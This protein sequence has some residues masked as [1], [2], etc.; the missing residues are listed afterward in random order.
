MHACRSTAFLLAALA[1][2]V[3]ASAGPAILI[4]RVYTSPVDH[5]TRFYDI[6]TPTGYT[7]A[8]A[9][10]LPAVLFLHG[11]GGSRGAFEKASYEAEADARGYILIFWQGR[12]DESVPAYSTD[13][14][15]G[16]RG[17]PDETDVLACLDNAMANYRIDSERVHLVGFSQGGKGALLIGL[18]NPD[19]FAT[20][21]EGAGPSDAFQG[22]AWSPGFPDYAAAAGGDYRGGSGSVL[23]RWFAQSPRFYLPNGRNLPMA[24]YHGTADTTVPDSTTLFPYRNTHH[25]ADTPGFAD[26]RGARP[27]LSELHRDDPSGYSYQTSYPQGVGH[28]EEEVLQAKPL[29]DFMSGKRR[30]VRPE[31][32]VATSYDAAERSYYWA[33]LGRMSPLDGEPAGFSATAEAS[34]NSFTLQPHGSPAITLRVPQAGLDPL[35]PLTLQLEPGAASLSSLRLSGAFP[36]RLLVTRNSVVLRA[37]IDF[38]REGSD[39]LFSALDSSSPMR[40][41]LQEEPVA[42]VVE[43]DLLVPALV[44]ASGQLGARFST[45]LTVANLGNV[46]LTVDA[47][48]LDGSGAATRLELA[49][50]RSQSFPSSELFS[51]LGKSGGA[52]PLRL[53]VVSGTPAALLASARVFNTLTR[54]GTYGLSFPVV[55]AG[56]SVLQAGEQAYFFGG[57]AEHPARTNISL[58]APFEGVTARVDLVN[59][60]GTTLSSVPV[61]LLPLARVQLDD[62]LAAVPPPGRVLVTVESG[63]AQ[64]YGTVV[65]NSVTNDP[66]RSPALLRSANSTEWTV[67]AVAAAPGRNGA[68]FSSDI[69]LGSLPGVQDFFIDVEL[70]FRSR[71]GRPPVTVTTAIIPGTARALSDVIGTFFPGS[72]PGAGALEIRSAFGLELLAVTRS[73]SPEGPASQDLPCFSKDQAFTEASPAAFAGVSEFSGARSNLVLVNKG[74]ST[75]VTLRLVSE[76]GFSIPVSVPLLAGEIKQIDS[77]AR[78]LSTQ[79]T[80][81]SVLLVIPAP[82]GRLVASVARIDNLTNDPSG[83]APLSFPISFAGTPPQ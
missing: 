32:V 78:L 82:G 45:E 14:I 61:T 13:Y 7:A 47:L 48:L 26:S 6:R 29:F 60:F 50:Q 34:G 74:A 44:E 57:T 73:D 59:D 39:V 79:D 67:P 21:S 70:T 2:A 83:L 19:R 10:P 72:V 23:A 71:D 25:I 53:R 62:V 64:V 69:F 22:Q 24:L 63:R 77:V 3:R 11:R 36:Q 68:T 81:S 9:T 16:V 35:R 56:A 20:L 5:A 65:S 15:D 80:V 8:S 40:L 75:S 18:K 58:F 49:P 12:F 38:T 76:T 51:R 4:D 46:P 28:S 1:F 17:F 66:F 55:A 30:V 31:R 54:G 42:A 37:G 33:R 43:N 41:V 27:T 52:S